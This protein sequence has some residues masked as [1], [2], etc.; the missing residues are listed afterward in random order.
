MRTW[1]D[2]PRIFPV[3]LF[4]NIV[5]IFVVNMNVARRLTLHCAAKIGWNQGSLY[6]SQQKP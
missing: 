5:Y 4:D 2:P 3:V 6:V 1:R